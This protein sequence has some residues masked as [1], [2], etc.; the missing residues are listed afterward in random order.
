M[1]FVIGWKTFFTIFHKNNKINKMPVPSFRI[2]CC[3]CSPLSLSIFGRRR[4]SKRFEMVWFS[5]WLGSFAR[6]LFFSAVITISLSASLSRWN[7]T[8]KEHHIRIHVA[9]RTKCVSSKQEEMVMLPFRVAFTDISGFF[10]C[11]SL[12]VL[13]FFTTIF[14][15]FFS[16]SIVVFFFSWCTLIF[17]YIYVIC[18][19]RFHQNSY[20]FVYLQISLLTLLSFNDDRA[21]TTASVHLFDERMSLC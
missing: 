2:A 10:F 18:S 11:K 9:T 3:Y 15:F 1:D 13:H 16:P 7:N 14:C 4:W 19:S 17:F 5:V 8:I 21:P 12:C 20:Y 6:F